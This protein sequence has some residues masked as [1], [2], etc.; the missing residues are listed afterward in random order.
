MFI[1]LHLSDKKAGPIAY[2]GGPN[3]LGQPHHNSTWPMSKKYKQ[4]M[5]ASSL[6]GPN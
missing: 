2:N 5:A 1:T 6:N 4:M 3:E